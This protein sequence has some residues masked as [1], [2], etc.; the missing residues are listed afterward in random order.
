MKITGSC[1]CG[2]IN[3]SAEIVPEKIILCHCIDCQKMSGAPYRGVVISSDETFSMTGTIKDYV[4]K[5]AASGTPRAQGFCPECGTHI[6]ATAIGDM[7][8]DTAR[9]YM[10]RLGTVDNNETLKPTAE[11]WCDSR[12]A[13]VD[14]IEGAAQVAQQPG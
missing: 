12:Q 11:I 5:T 8:A 13:W 14:P 6:Y 10:I 7:P 1:H 9:P 2:N 4:K 3:Y